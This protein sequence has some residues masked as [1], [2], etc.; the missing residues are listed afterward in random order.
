MLISVIIPYNVSFVEMI[1]ISLYIID[2]RKL[3]LFTTIFW[4]KLF[5]R[6][7]IKLTNYINV[8]I[9]FKLSKFYV[10]E[11]LEVAV[12]FCILLFRRVRP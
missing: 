5:F 8:E 10:L 11:V 9:R 7:F 6:A 4:L 3:H 1:Q 2:T 12:C